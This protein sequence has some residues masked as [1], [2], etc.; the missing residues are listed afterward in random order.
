M[1]AFLRTTIKIRYLTLLIVAWL[2]GCGHSEQND[3]EK[4]K[5]LSNA[6]AKAFNNADAEGIAIHFTDDAVLMPPGKPSITGRKAVANYYQSVFD[7][8]HTDLTSEYKEVNVEGDLAYGRGHARVTLI[9]KS[10]K[11]TI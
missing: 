8:Y 11:D 2:F 10:G 7:E 1:K 4:I 9:A 5:K 3:V 6:R